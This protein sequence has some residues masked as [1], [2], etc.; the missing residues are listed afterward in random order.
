MNTLASHLV[1]VFLGCV[2]TLGALEL[3]H[4]AQ[5]PEEPQQPYVVKQI[6]LPA[7]VVKPRRATPEQKQQRLEKR[8]QTMLALIKE[9]E[10]ARKERS[11]ERL[12]SLDP[13][14]RVERLLRQ[15]ETIDQKLNEYLEASEPQTDEDETV[16]TGT[17]ADDLQGSP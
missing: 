6:V 8:K 15:Q 4:M 14:E 7:P 17:P 2:L 5:G 3:W 12:K 13:E 9:R 16:D 11:Q 10:K 1:S